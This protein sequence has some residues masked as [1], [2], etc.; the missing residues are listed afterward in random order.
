MDNYISGPGYE[1]FYECNF[2]LVSSGKWARWAVLAV[3]HL[4]GPDL[5]PVGEAS[6]LC[7][8]CKVRV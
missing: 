5:Y 1:E 4:P 7:Y 3:S 6:L 8:N 2:S